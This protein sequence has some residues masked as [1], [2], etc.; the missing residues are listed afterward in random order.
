[1]NGIRNFALATAA[2][3][4]MVSAPAVC[5]AADYRGDVQV[6]YARL[7][8]PGDFPDLNAA[9][10]QGRYFFKPVTTDGLPLAEAAFLG[11]ASSVSLAAARSESSFGVGVFR[12]N[13]QSASVGYYIPGTMF[14]AGVSA[15][16]NE[17]ITALNSTIVLTDYDTNWSGV[18]G[19]TPVDG[20]LISTV[21][22]ERGYDPNITARY[23]GKLPNAH[24][25]AGSVS[26]VDPDQGDTSFGVDFDYYFDESF[27]AGVAYQDGSE[28]LT[29]K[30]RKFFTPRFSLGGSYTSGDFV[31][32]F[33]V[34][35]AWRF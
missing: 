16:R 19:I 24:Y 8:G 4:S 10:I 3:L 30:V 20:L 28:S 6:S 23:V 35:V 15:S 11:R 22:R 33:N 31:D 27:S 9:W 17:H 25:Y 26:I 29:G 14:F 32:S 21:L 13:S 18:L 2:L 1:M 34:D 5:L 12:L 7:L